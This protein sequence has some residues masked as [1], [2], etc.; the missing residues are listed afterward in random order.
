MSGCTAQGSRGQRQGWAY[1][2]S[3]FQERKASPA[4]E[5][6]GAV[7][8]AGPEQHRPH[9]LATNNP[10]DG[11]APPPENRSL[12]GMN[13]N[14]VQR[15][16]LHCCP[17]EMQTCVYVWRVP[18][19]SPTSMAPRGTLDRRPAPQ[20]ASHPTT[21]QYT[22]VGSYMHTKHI[23]THAGAPQPFSTFLPNSGAPSPK[24]NQASITR[25]MME[26]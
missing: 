22:R 9:P 3:L 6:L 17:Q 10:V 2:A 19:A 12:P 5:G 23:H 11:G 16:H 4:S 24:P 20:T 1:E 13:G 7:V 18:A 15:T 25:R 8:T 26:S 14:E 21:Q